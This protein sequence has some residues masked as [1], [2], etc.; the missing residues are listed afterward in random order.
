[1]IRRAPD[2]DIDVGELPNGSEQF[3]E[4]HCPAAHILK[5]IHKSW[6]SEVRV[7][8]NFHR[9]RFCPEVTHVF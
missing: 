2:S 8:I 1:M 6:A 4:N 5:M 9:E 7:G 3:P